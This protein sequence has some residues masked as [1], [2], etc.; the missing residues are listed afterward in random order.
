MKRHGGCRKA[1]AAS[2]GK[3][4]RSGTEQHTA[5]QRNPGYSLNARPELLP[6][7]GAERMLEAVSSRLLFG[8]AGALAALPMRRY[9]GTP[10]SRRRA[11]LACVSI[12]RVS[13]K[14]V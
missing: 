3:R 8:Q 14:P 6:E 5:H 13:A 2:V 12:A 9:A 11:V 4:G 10:S 1:A 7:G